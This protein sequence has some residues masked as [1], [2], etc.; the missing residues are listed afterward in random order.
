MEFWIEL[1]PM[2]RHA[3]TPPSPELSAEEL[4]RYLMGHIREEA[5]LTRVTNH[6]IDCPACAQ[7]ARA[8]AAYIRTMREALQEF[9]REGSTLPHE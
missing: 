1:T 5:E 9:E 3:H 8:T 2:P 6:L 7:R 4:E